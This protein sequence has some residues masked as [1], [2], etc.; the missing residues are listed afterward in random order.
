MLCD[1]VSAYARMRPSA[2]AFIADDEVLS[3][4]HYD[5]RSD[6]LA[7]LL[8]D[9]GLARGE[10]IGLLLPDSAAANTAFLACEKSGVIGMAI[11][12]RAGEVEIEHLLR[13][14][15][16]VALLTED[17]DGE[18]LFARMRAKGL[19][20][21]HHLIVPSRAQGAPI[22]AGARAAI[23]ER[24][25]KPDDVFL[26]NSTSGTSGMPKCVT[27]HQS[28][29]FAFAEFAYDAAQLSA[30]DVFL[31]AIPAS[32]GF[33]LWTGHFSPALLGAPT[34]VLPKFSVEAL[35]QA[36]ERHRVSVLAA[37]STQFIMM[38]NE[39]RLMDYDLRSLR[40]L[41][42]GGEAV[43][44]E[45][46]AR[47]EERTGAKV[48]QF[49]G[50]NE[51]GAVSY[52]STRDSREQ[53]L[54][55]AGRVIDAMQLRLLNETVGPEP[56]MRQGQPACNGPL[57]CQGYWNNEPGNKELYTDDGW[58]TMSDI[59]SIDEAGYL[60]VIGRVGDFIIRGGKNISA[61]AV[62]E[63]VLHHPA[64]STAAAVAMPDAIFGERVCIYVALKPGHALALAELAAFLK[65]QGISKEWIP[66][67]MIIMPELPTV[68]GGKIA[69][70]LL[71][72]DI[73]ARVRAAD[74]R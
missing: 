12:A 22:S 52:T 54:R 71:R 35:L 7:A 44:Y 62:E 2:P 38:L 37:V 15:G 50:S 30:G 47:F 61:A 18:A 25:A 73:Q 65:E 53:R 64:V 55:T 19:P 32:V 51:T 69:K 10:R 1:V 27:Q 36:I 49:Y 72:A 39:P 56:G 14:C 63:A 58:M 43:P 70:H 48:L 16:A 60:K 57:M 9:A 13:V 21:H 31:R 29:W 66:E 68:S 45:R 5:A 11:S 26:L 8:I 59:V 40:V 23:A 6:Q 74:L 42:T 28:R 67:H 3:W 4:A 41:F 34:V 33:G 20:L 46:A 17:K 24:R